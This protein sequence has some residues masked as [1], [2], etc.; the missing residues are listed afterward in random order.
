MIG[1]QAV[2][3]LLRL[4]TATAVG[5]VTA[6]TLFATH[7]RAA[8]AG[9]VCSLVPPG[10]LPSVHVSGKCQLLAPT[11]AQWG[12][13]SGNHGLELSVELIP[14]NVRA[15]VLPRFRSEVLKNGAPIHAVHGIASEYLGT[16]SCSNPPTGDCIHGEIMVL[17]GTSAAQI[18]LYDTAQF[19]RADDNTDPAVDEAN[20]A[21]Q[22]NK[23]RAAFAAIGIAASGKL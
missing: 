11:T 19:I 23:D 15:I 18:Q 4:L 17:T 13:A 6:A 2:L 21:A 16:Y 10:A 14:A 9:G 7:S 3:A 8:P 22:E 12:S 20:D 1:Q 5:L